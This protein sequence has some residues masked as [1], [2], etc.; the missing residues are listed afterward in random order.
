MAFLGHKELTDGEKNLFVFPSFKDDEN[1]NDF[2]N[3]EKSN[4]ME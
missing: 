4:E 1:D 3:D 2:S